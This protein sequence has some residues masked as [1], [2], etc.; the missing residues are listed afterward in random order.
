MEVEAAATMLTAQMDARTQ[1]MAAKFLKQNAD[2]TAAVAGLIEA[3]Q[4]SLDRIVAAAGPG[5]GG[6]VDVSV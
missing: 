6:I 1:F 4:N 5:K 2:A 3:G